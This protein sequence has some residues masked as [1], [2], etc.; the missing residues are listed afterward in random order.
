MIEINAQGKDPKQVNAEIKKALAKEGSVTVKNAEQCY[1]LGS[2]LRSGILRVEGDANDYV[3]MVNSG[4]EIAISGNARN[5]LGDNMTSGKITV[6]G[7]AGYGAGMYTYGGT[8]HVKGDAGDFTATMNKGATIIIGGNVGHDV[9]TYMVKGDLILLGN[10]G[11]NLGNFLIRGTIFVAG[12]VESLGHNM[13]ERIEK[14]LSEGGFGAMPG[15]LRKFV[16]L[17]DKPFYA[18]KVEPK[19]KSGKEA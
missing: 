10:V 1:G 7:N 17:T 6:E 18:A 9:G 13:K 19:V 4:L 12:K 14:L 15:N 16:P 8:M 2:G 3:G 5:F 11:K